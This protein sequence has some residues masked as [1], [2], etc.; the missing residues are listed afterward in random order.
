MTQPDPVVSGAGNSS[1][2]EHRGGGERPGGLRFVWRI[3]VS[4]GLLGVALYVVGPTE[5]VAA[6]R[7]VEPGV[8]VGVVVLQI[9]GLGVGAVGIWVLV[10]TFLASVPFLPVASVYLRSTALGMF[11]PGKFGELVFPHFLA[12][13]G[14]SIG[15]GLAVL[16]VDK[17]I[18]FVCAAVIGCVGL[19]LLVGAKQALSVALLSGLLVSLAL[20]MAASGKLRRVARERLLGKHHRRFE[21]FSASLFGLLREER[22][23]VAV[24]GILTVLRFLLRGGA[25]AA[26]FYALGSPVPFLPT[27]ALLCLI[28]IL[29]WLPVSVSGLG[30]TQG[31]AILLFALLL[32]AEQAVVL[33]AFLILP[34]SAYI[35]AA[36]SLGVLGVKE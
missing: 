4:V 33:N 10:R 20:L 36:A 29:S 11:A 34:A 18:T 13:Q 30:V 15:A 21:G 9:L 2:V 22:R 31:S 8:L 6:F 27:V 35:L 1:V 5:T 23:A 28:Q 24:N 16:L 14:V 26:A 19:L 25:A 32:Q 3:V 12:R 7:A 17:L